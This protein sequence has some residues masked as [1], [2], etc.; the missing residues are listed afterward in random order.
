MYSLCLRTQLAPDWSLECGNRNFYVFGVLG[1]DKAK[2]VAI[3]LLEF[4]MAGLPFI[5]L[6]VHEDME[7]L[8]SRDRLHLT[9]NAHRQYPMLNDFRERGVEDV[10]RFAGVIAV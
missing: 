6:V 3:C 10:E 7:A 5:S 2:N 8:G 9:R 1:N 4:R